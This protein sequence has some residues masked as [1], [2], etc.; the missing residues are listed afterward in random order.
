V[1]TRVGGIPDLILDE[2]MGRL[3]EA[4]DI[5]ALGKALVELCYNPALCSTFGT[6]AREHILTH[7]DINWIWCQFLEMVRGRDRLVL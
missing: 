6:K 5:Q 2:G 7:H 1:A 3:V 4:D